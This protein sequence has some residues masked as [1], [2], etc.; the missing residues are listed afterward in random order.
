MATGRRARTPLV[1]VVLAF[2]ALASPPAG[3][4]TDPAPMTAE[5]RAAETSAA[6]AAADRTATRGPAAVTL[7]D[8]GKLALPEGYVY[9]PGAE[10]GRVLRSYGNVVDPSLVGLVTGTGDE[11][12]WMAVI[13]F[14]KEGYIKDDD[15]KDW[16][17]DDLLA[18]LK[19]GTEAANA[20]RAKRGF[21]AVEIIGWVE[22]PAYDATAHHLVWS[23]SSRAADEP[24]EADRGVNY[25]TYALGRDGYFSLNLLTSTDKVEARKPIAHALLSDLDY[26][27]GKRYADFN[28][29]T[30]TIAAYGLAALVGGVAV[31]KLGLFALALAFF[32]KFAKIGILALVAL[33]AGIGKLFG[34]KPKTQSRAQ[35]QSAD[36]PAPDK[37]IGRAHV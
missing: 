26:V 13:R 17:A 30:D 2:L 7:L 20:E 24:A 10:A 29:T 37:Q 15:A 3:A 5:Q 19:Q 4:Q 9:V 11:A 36:S 25:N 16:N 35:A 34:R 22:K 6:W 32:A 14:V 12:D 23:L 8:Q 33:G 28:G 21:P 1:T 18:S 31:K 27:P